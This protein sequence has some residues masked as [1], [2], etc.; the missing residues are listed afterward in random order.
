MALAWILLWPVSAAGC[1][2][3]NG[4]LECGIGARS[5]AGLDLGVP[6]GDA[7]V[8]ILVLATIAAGGWLLTL[9]AARRD[10]RPLRLAL[11]FLVLGLALSVGMVLAIG[12]G[13]IPADVTMGTD[14][15]I[16][17]LVAGGVIG[18]AALRTAR[19]YALGRSLLAVAVAGAILVGL[20]EWLGH[21]ELSSRTATY[22][23]L[24]PG[25]IYFTWSTVTT[26]VLVPA[27][28]YTGLALIVGSIACGIA[29]ITRR[30]R[31]A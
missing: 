3:T 17:V 26:F 16:A 6:V 24:Q 1:L 30:V 9:S 11:G 13:G 4:T 28:G 5:L 15:A 25:Q 21:V 18:L 27:L 10:Q 23:P 22:V 2:P 7:Q 19:R 31:A 8:A 14:V 12:L 29:G 20:A